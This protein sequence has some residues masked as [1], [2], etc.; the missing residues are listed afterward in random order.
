MTVCGVINLCVQTR[1][2]CGQRHEPGMR[3]LLDK[4]SKDFWT[5]KEAM[6]NRTVLYALACLC[7]VRRHLDSPAEASASRRATTR[8]SETAVALGN[9]FP[10]G[11]PERMCRGGRNEVSDSS[12]QIQ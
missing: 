3:D 7:F 5:F 1:R 12:C 4:S 2:L 6:T 9:S 11:F 10:E 8:F